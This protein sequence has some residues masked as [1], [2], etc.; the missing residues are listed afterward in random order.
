MSA[1]LISPMLGFL[2]GADIVVV[3]VVALLIFGPKKLP[4]L[5]RGLGQGLR[6]FKKASQDVLDELSSQGPSPDEIRRT[7]RSPARLAA[8]ELLPPEGGPLT[9]RQ[10]VEEVSPGRTGVAPVDAEVAPAPAM[11]L[12]ETP[13]ERLEAPGGVDLP[14]AAPGLEATPTPG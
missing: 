2:G 6:E 10:G 7:P 14:S 5:A 1:G 13:S 12:V 3:L 11:E 9:G 8:A 4:E